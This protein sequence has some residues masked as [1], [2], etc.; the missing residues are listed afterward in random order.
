M[1]WESVVGFIY[2][3]RCE[4]RKWAG[5]GAI[6]P[7]GKQPKNN[8]YCLIEMDLTVK[9]TMQRYGISDADCTHWVKGQVLGF[10]QYSMC[11]RDAKLPK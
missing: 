11:L 3:P 5:S 10:G 1:L 8:I 6:L 9:I 7:W 4:W 2:K